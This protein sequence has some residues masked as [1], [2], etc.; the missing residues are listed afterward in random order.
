M[1]ITLQSVELLVEGLDWMLSTVVVDDDEE[2]A[3]VVV[4]AI[5]S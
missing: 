3:E 1:D 4:V 2:A 5:A